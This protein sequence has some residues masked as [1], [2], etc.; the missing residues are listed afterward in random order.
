MTASVVQ[1][2]HNTDLFGTRS[3]LRPLSSRET[4]QRAS[5]ICTSRPSPKS[6][7]NCSRMRRMKSRVRVAQAN[8]GLPLFFAIMFAI[9]SL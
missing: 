2:A 6:L 3:V 1:S 8:D 5:A 9:Q 7:G 4:M